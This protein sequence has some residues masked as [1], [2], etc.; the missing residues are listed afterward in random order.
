MLVQGLVTLHL[1]IPE[2]YK[3]NRLFTAVILV[4]YI[5][6]NVTY[7][8]VGGHQPNLLKNI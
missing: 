7:G 3:G 5:S 1:T 4:K 8:L 6:L 2:P